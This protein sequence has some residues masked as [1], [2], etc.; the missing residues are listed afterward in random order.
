MQASEHAADRLRETMARLRRQ[1][2]EQ[3]KITI[4]AQFF[5]DQHGFTPLRRFPRGMKDRY[6]CADSECSQAMQIMPFT[7]RR[8]PAERMADSAAQMVAL[9]FNVVQ[10]SVVDHLHHATPAIAPLIR[11]LDPLSVRRP[12]PQKISF[13]HYLSPLM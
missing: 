2:S 7:A 1:V 8:R 5:S 9:T 6:G 12:P 3:G 11:R 13:G 10:A 4:P